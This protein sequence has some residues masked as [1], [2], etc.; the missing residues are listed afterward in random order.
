[1]W[2]RQWQPTPVFL[3]GESQ[4][5]GSL[6]GCHLWGC[7]VG[8]DWSDLALFHCVYV[9][10]LLYPS[11]C[12]WTS[13]LLP[14]S[15]AA[16]AAAKPLQSCLTLQPHRWQPTRVPCPWDSPGKNPGVVC[17]L[18]LQCRKGKSKSEVTQSCP[19]LHDPMDCS[20]P[21]SSVHGIF[22]ARVLEWSAIAFSSNIWHHQNDKKFLDVNELNTLTYMLHPLDFFPSFNNS[23]VSNDE[24]V[25]NYS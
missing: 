2:R 13:R 9:P 20:P 8:H 5:R 22:Q 14:C 19:A 23:V 11:I 3:P 12:W 4:G 18:L 7:R 10:Q 17:H 15:A 6:V 21:G 25:I 1:M 16:A 24:K